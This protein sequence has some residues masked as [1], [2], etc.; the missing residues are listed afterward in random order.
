M[1][2]FRIIERD[3]VGYAHGSGWGERPTAFE[4]FIH[5]PGAAP[6]PGSFADLEQDLEY[7]RYLDEIG[8]QRFKYADLTTEG[9]DAWP[10]DP[11][12]GI[13]YSLLFPKS[14]RIIR[15]HDP[16][17]QSSHTKGHNYSG[18]G[19]CILVSEGETPNQQQMEAVAWAVH[20]QVRRGELVAP[21]ITGGHRDVYPTICPTDRVYDLIPQ[22]RAL[23]AGETMAKR[24]PTRRDFDALVANQ[25]A[26]GFE[27]YCTPYSHDRG[28]CPLHGKPRGSKGP[29][30]WDS[31]HRVARALD[32]GWPGAP[33]SELE[34]IHVLLE[35]ER[36]ANDPHI[37][38]RRLFNISAT[39]HPDHGHV[40][41]MGGIWGNDV[42]DRNN[43]MAKDGITLFVSPKAFPGHIPPVNRDGGFTLANGVE[44]QKAMNRVI[45]PA[46]K[47]PFYT[48]SFDG[49]LGP[50]SRTGAREIQEFLGIDVDGRPGGGTLAAIRA[51]L[52]TPKGPD[53]SGFT[54]AQIL[55]AQRELKVAGWYLDTLDGIPGPNFQAAMDAAQTALAKD[56][57]YK[58][59]IDLLPG[60]NFMTA[61]R[62]WNDR[63]NEPP[64]P[65][66]AQ[67]VAKF[68][69]AGSNAAE[70]AVTAA[71]Y[72]PPAGKGLVLY[73]RNTPDEGAALQLV[74][75][76]DKGTVA[77]PVNSDGTVSSSITDYARSSGVAWVRAVGGSAS[78]TNTGLSKVL[79]AA[80]IKY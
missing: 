59:E 9:I 26:R 24:R 6:P 60:P 51:Y 77:L 64:P 37:A 63:L 68:R 38:W 71:E 34:Q 21:T 8:Y 78:V 56:G 30:S 1:E 49:Y 53:Y 39:N 57:L 62:L 61:I 28:I 48:G 66:L 47:R 5:Y 76:S 58:D 45:N 7:A 65:T 75:R 54:S 14:G 55:D 16:D 44:A 17:R 32:F 33:I 2:D 72:V 10:G 13:S 27:H 43:V 40:D 29:H 18:M 35:M 52:E 41:D 19:Y 25:K 22:M 73:R 42:R 70:T 79:T 3:E 23:V 67:R 80:R 69:I 31:R 50:K 12:A 4:V 46:T 15:G 20:E 74:W 11:G 36:L